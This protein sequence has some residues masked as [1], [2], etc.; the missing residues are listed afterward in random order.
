MQLKDTFLRNYV[1]IVDMGLI[2]RLASPSASDREKITGSPYA[3]K[4]YADKVFDLIMS[5]H[6][7]ATT[8]LAVNDYYDSDV[9]NTKD[10]EHQKRSQAFLGGQM[11]NVFPASDRKFPPKKEFKDFFRN[12][13]IKV[14][15][16][17]YLK[18][19]FSFQCRTLSKRFIYQG[20]D[21]C[22]DISSSSLRESVESL[23]CSHLEADTAM[24][25]VYSK[26]REGD[27]TTP[28]LIDSIA[29]NFVVKK[30]QKSLCLYMLSLGAT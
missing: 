11:K 29:S 30:W 16:Q 17:S 10:G 21:I 8:I 14:W 20:K 6:P 13:L 19:Y 27:Q 9:I 5:R 24:I 23:Q 18:S 28:V 2:W 1:A 7:N 12:P 26:I 4:N 22:D 15:L 3:W 25:F